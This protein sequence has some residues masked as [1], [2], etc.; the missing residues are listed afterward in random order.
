MWIPSLLLKQKVAQPQ[1]FCKTAAFTDAGIAST[2]I[3]MS[4]AIFGISMNKIKKYA[5][6]G[7]ISSRII[8]KI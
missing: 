4:E 8:L 2:T 5:I 7:I 6:S 3:H 1:I